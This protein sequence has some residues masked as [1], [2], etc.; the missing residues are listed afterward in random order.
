MSTADACIRLADGSVM[1]INSWVWEAL[2][3]YYASLTPSELSQQRLTRAT[4][5]RTIVGL[6]NGDLSPSKR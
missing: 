1:S 5:N 6:Q 4:I 3:R 2:D